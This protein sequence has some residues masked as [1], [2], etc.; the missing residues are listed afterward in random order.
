MYG[1]RKLWYKKEQ[2]LLPPSPKGRLSQVPMTT[3]R[4]IP[5]FIIGY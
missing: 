3:M 2:Q 1:L 5:K 4:K